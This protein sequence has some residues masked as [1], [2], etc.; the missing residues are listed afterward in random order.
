MWA[1]ASTSSSGITKREGEFVDEFNDRVHRHVRGQRH[2]GG[3]TIL[4]GIRFAYA[5]ASASR[6][7]V[8]L[9]GRPMPTWIRP[10]GFSVRKID[11]GGY[12][13]PG[14]VRPC[15]STERR[16]AGILSRSAGR[17][18]PA[19]H[20][21]ESP[22]SA[23]TPA[24]RC[25]KPPRKGPRLYTATSVLMPH[26]HNQPGRRDALASA[27]TPSASNGPQP[28]CSRSSTGSPESP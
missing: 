14:H 27:A 12:Y 1:V 23:G 2:E 9:A 13:L 8:P 19:R 16:F 5:G 17:S 10:E 4:A 22:R 25:G 7:R 3:P 21:P 6:R 28:A 15:A 20:P 26:V 18:C 24:A 11:L